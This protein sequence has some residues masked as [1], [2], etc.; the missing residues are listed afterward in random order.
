MAGTAQRNNKNKNAIQP[1]FKGTV[2]VGANNTVRSSRSFLSRLGL[3]HH[4]R[5]WWMI[6]RRYAGEEG[7][8]S[9]L[10]MNWSFVLAESDRIISKALEVPLFFFF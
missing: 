1:N 8:V 3:A 9:D 7:D 4:R 5:W 6:P 2:H 10:L